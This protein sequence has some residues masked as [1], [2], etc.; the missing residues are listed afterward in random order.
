MNEN[1]IVKDELIG[2]RV[3]IKESRDPSLVHKSGTILD[4][5]MNT[6]LIEIE[7]KQKRIA[8]HIAT[9]EFEFEGKKF[10]INGSRLRFR[11]EDRIKKAR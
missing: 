8:K 5:T 7:H 11:P 9:F 4:E 3:R 2:K 6:F 1:D 10:L